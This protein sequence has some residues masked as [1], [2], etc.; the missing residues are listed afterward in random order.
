M[1][2]EVWR[3]PDK[4]LDIGSRFREVYKLDPAESKAWEM[5]ARVDPTVARLP[6]RSFY[7]KWLG[8]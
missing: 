7:C 3:S 6:K 5:S 8:L 1:F 2:F 4:K